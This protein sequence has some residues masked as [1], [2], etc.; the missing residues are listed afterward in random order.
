[1]GRDHGRSCVVFVTS[2]GGLMS[3]LEKERAMWLSERVV[4]DPVN[5]RERESVV[6]FDLGAFDPRFTALILR[7]GS[8][9]SGD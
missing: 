9:K 5:G 2:P 7:F 4:D 6:L 3:R 1:M 8:S